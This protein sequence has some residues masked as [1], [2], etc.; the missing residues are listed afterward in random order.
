MRACMLS[1]FQLC[2]T[3]C[4]FLDYRARQAPLAMEFSRQEY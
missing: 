2:P 4:E 3:L 1:R